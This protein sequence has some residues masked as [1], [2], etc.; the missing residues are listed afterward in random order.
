MIAPLPRSP[1][2]AGVG[3]LLLLVLAAV[4][5][6][7]QPEPPYGRGRGGEIVL[8][9]S[10]FGLGAFAME[11]IG[12]RTSLLLE[13]SFGIVKDE[14]ETKYFDLTGS[15]I[16]NKRTV[17]YSLPARIGLSRR[18]FARHIE[19]NVRP[20]VQASVGPT[21]GWTYPYFDDCNANG[22]FDRTAVDCDDD[23][24]AGEAERALGFFEAQ[25]Q[26]K[27]L[28]GAGGLVGAGAHMGFGRRLLG[29]RMAYRWDYYP[30]GVALLEADIAE[31]RRLFS[32]VQLS[33][34]FGHLVD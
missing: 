28:L 30:T 5:V 3:A 7:A 33:F 21:V 13:T 20:F 32:T 29:L 22:L 6:Q 19:P 18:L 8:T 34:T 1:G 24:Q 16:L 10:G 12:R 14:R 27:I 2:Q 4:P 11:P 15:A 17:L 25:Q 9:S 26:A 23:G 31:R